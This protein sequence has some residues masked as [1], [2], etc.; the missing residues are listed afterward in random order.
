MGTDPHA[1]QVFQQNV[2]SAVPAESLSPPVLQEWL[3][4]VYL[5]PLSAQKLPHEPSGL[6]QQ[7]T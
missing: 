3:L 2:S 4:F 7:R 5:T 6:R 1:A